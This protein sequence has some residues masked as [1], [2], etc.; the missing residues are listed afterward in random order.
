MSSFEGK[1]QDEGWHL[2][3]LK[4]IELEVLDKRINTVISELNAKL[5]T[6]VFPRLE[7]DCSA[8]LNAN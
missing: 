8:T 5:R 2:T 6:V 3:G 7:I 1:R 4:E